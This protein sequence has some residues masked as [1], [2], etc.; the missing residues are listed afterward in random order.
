MDLIFF[1]QKLTYFSECVKRKRKWK[2]VLTRMNGRPSSG[3]LPAGA[4]DWASDSRSPAAGCWPLRER[5]PD[6]R[7]CCGRGFAA[8]PSHLKRCRAVVECESGDTGRWEFCGEKISS[9]GNEVSPLFQPWIKIRQFYAASRLRSLT[10]TSVEGIPT[11]KS[12]F[13]ETLLSLRNYKISR[14]S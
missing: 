7:F 9:S 14:D 13:L 3:T 12:S 5:G 1:L 6:T 8:R 4:S 2:S 10:K 11:S